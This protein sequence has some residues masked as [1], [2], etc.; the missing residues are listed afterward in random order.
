MSSRCGAAACEPP[1]RR[2][3]PRAA[4][5][6]GAIAWAAHAALRC[7]AYIYML[8]YGA[9]RLHMLH[10]DATRLYMLHYDATRCSV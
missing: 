6:S 9:T 2:G 7:K 1:G 5:Q 10:Y 4:L 8:H 3:A